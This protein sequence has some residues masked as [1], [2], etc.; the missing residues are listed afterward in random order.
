MKIAIA[1]ERVEVWR[2]GAET[3]TMELARLLSERG[4]EVHI[5]TST[6][7][8]SLP[9]LPIH[10]IPVSKVLRPLRTS[11]FAR[12]TTAFLRENR[13]D[14]VH[15]VSPLACADVYQ[16]RG[17][18]IGETAARNVATRS[19]STQRMMK[20]ALLAMNFKQRVL[21]DLERDVFRKGGPHILAVSRY[22]ARQCKE[23]YGAGE[24][25]VRVVFNG[26]GI[27]PITP[28]ERAKQRASIRAQYG[29]RDNVLSILFVAH[30]FR[31]KGL[32]SLIETASRLV[33]SGFR[34][35]HVF[36][37]GR[38]NP[39][40]YSRRIASLGLGE[41]MTFVGPTRRV[42]S[43]YCA[44]DICVHPTYYDPCSR[45]VL[46]SL[47]YG[48][49]CIASA[50]DGASEVIRDGQDGFVIDSPDS[51][52]LWARRITE[53]KSADLRDR[54]SARSL[55]LRDRI[56]MARH[57]DELDAVFSEIAAAKR[58]ARETV[59]R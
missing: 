58:Q 31:L 10:H 46:E 25:R 17:G 59:H 40:R 32:S 7:A 2:G 5:I 19:S 30:N 54:M 35:F 37:V 33:V 49:P 21:L 39:V 38:D 28:E 42:A 15:A 29:L 12:K 34:D 52:G 6:P 45:V 23:T 47:S 51:I 20:R 36:V 9:N 16:P 56:S 22:V 1:I 24:P 18:L 13:F 26:V 50:F 41:Q 44:A 4:H 14:L 57:V 27:E 53:L 3:S 55:L 48:V 8:Q 43:F 11:L